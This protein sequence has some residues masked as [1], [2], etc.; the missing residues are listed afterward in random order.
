MHAQ[1][2]IR[3]KDLSNCEA[4]GPPIGIAL[5]PGVSL[6][7]IR[8]CSPPGLLFPYPIDADGILSTVH[9]LDR[10]GMLT[11]RQ[12][13]DWKYVCKDIERQIDSIKCDTCI[14]LRTR[15]HEHPTSVRQSDAENERNKAIRDQ[16][17]ADLLQH[18]SNDDLVPSH[19]L[20]EE[21]HL[22]ALCPKLAPRDDDESSS[23]SDEDEPSPQLLSSRAVRRLLAPSSVTSNALTIHQAP[24]GTPP[25]GAQRQ[26]STNMYDP[27]Y[28][29]VTCQNERHRDRLAAAWNLSTRQLVV[30]LLTLV[31][32]SPE[33]IAV[34]KI[35]QPPDANRRMNI[36]WY[37]NM[38]FNDPEQ[39][40]DHRGPY[41]EME[42]E[43]TQMLD[44][45]TTIL[46]NIKLTKDGKIAK[47]DF[48]VILASN[49]IEMQTSSSSSSSSS[50]S[51]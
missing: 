42:D 33:R 46:A 4:Y 49:R 38:T 6:A 34:V 3:D 31:P 39:D 48:T 35:L 50:S 25:T 29:G 19:F 5:L 47:N 22:F 8:A 12:L 1:V 21:C 43:Y 13:R 9:H 18:M 15:M 16:A 30:V 7:D 23:S 36:L 32:G 44:L 20:E 10:L 28:Q 2:T 27:P 45:D 51:E 14:E 41:K 26:G 40:F 11:P 24:P 17:R 37:R